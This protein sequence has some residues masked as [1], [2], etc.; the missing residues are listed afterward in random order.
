MALSRKWDLNNSERFYKYSGI[1]TFANGYESHNLFGSLW[2]KNVVEGMQKLGLYGRPVISRGGPIGGH[3]Y[4]IPFAGDIA[5]GI[6]F[7]RTDLNWL[8]NGGLSLYSFC[9]V[10][11]GGFIDRG[12]KGMNPLEEHNVIRRMVNMVP[13]VPISRSH[14]SGEFGAMLPWQLTPAQQDLYRYYLKLRYRLHPYLYSSAIEALW[15][16]Y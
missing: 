12:E 11:L 8:R 15:R 1:K 13:I 3:R 4:I 7:I 2:A 14:G 9:L 6:E 16:R 10:E 5:H